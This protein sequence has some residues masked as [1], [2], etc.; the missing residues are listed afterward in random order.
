MWN[1]GHWTWDLD[2]HAVR[3]DPEIESSQAQ[4]ADLEITH[5]ETRFSSSETDVTGQVDTDFLSMRLVSL[6]SCV[7]TAQGYLLSPLLP[8]GMRLLP[9]PFLRAW[10]LQTP[11]P[12]P[13]LEPVVISLDDFDC[14][15]V[16][17]FADEESGC[18]QYWVCNEEVV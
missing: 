2:I 8:P 9:V 12:E 3:S 10:R 13:V 4:I 7:V 16:G 18:E 14:P 6:L 1:G 17:V 15:A 11:A 5:L